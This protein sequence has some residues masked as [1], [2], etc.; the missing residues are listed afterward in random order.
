MNIPRDAFISHF[1]PV[2]QVHCLKL[3]RQRAK[4]RL[5]HCRDA[6]TNGSKPPTAASIS[7]SRPFA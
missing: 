1:L 7:I 3:W 6:F 5:K 4:E 2:F